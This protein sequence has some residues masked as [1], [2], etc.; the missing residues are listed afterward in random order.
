MKQN[1]TALNEE[2]L[3]DLPAVYEDRLHFFSPLLAT[4]RET[5]RETNKRDRKRQR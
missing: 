3:G 5:E 2:L 4:V 1:Y